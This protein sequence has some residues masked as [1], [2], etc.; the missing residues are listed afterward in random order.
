MHLITP[1]TPGQDH[2]LMIGIFGKGLDLFGITL[3]AGEHE[4]V[5]LAGLGVFGAGDFV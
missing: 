1:D 4:D 2:S 5:Q 3:P